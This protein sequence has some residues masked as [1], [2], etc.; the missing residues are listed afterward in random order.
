MNLPKLT[1][2]EI[3]KTILSVLGLIALLYCYSA[4]LLG[5]LN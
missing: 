3:K 1:K 4:F 2:E 5:P